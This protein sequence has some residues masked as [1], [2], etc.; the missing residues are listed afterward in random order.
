[1]RQCYNEEKTVE[2]TYLVLDCHS[3]K[4]HP[5]NLPTCSC[6][7]LQGTGAVL[8]QKVRWTGH[9]RSVQKSP[10]FSQSDRFAE[11][12]GET[13]N[14]FSQNTDISK[15]S[16]SSLCLV[17]IG[18]RAFDLYFELVTENIRGYGPECADL[19]HHTDDQ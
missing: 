11:S 5:S 6:P 2:K 1:M 18:L 16:H 9:H 17:F 3:A 15:P 7:G 10:L 13:L 12:K 4:C 19:D 14:F 8:G